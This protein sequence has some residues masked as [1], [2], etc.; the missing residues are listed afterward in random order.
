MPAGKA[1]AAAASQQI[2]HSHPISLG[3]PSP[4]AYKSEHALRRT[5]LKEKKR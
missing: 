1:R 2:M 3:S 5:H 4:P